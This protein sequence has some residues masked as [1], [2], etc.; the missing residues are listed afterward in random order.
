MA[1]DLA[2][3]I[4]VPLLLAATF[5]EHQLIYLVLPFSVVSLAAIWRARLEVAPASSEDDV[6]R[7]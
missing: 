1:A 2:S 7:A 4:S 6:P 3:W 5:L